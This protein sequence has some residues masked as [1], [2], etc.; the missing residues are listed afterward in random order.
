MHRLASDFRGLENRYTRTQKWGAGTLG[1]ATA[2]CTSWWSLQSPTPQSVYGCGTVITVA[3]VTTTLETLKA[4][5]RK[6]SSLW[7]DTSWSA[8]FENAIRDLKFATDRLE[9]TTSSE[10]QQ[11]KQLTQACESGLAPA[12]LKSGSVW[13]PYPNDPLGVAPKGGPVHVDLL[14]RSTQCKALGSFVEAMT[15]RKTIRNQRRGVVGEFSVPFSK[16]IWLPAL[17]E[18]GTQAKKSANQ[19]YRSYLR[20]EYEW[21]AS[22]CTAR[23]KLWQF[24]NSWDS[25]SKLADSERNGAEDARKAEIACERALLAIPLLPSVSGRSADTGTALPGGW[26][27]RPVM[28][29]FG[30]AEYDTGGE[31]T[32]AKTEQYLRDG[33][34]SLARFYE[35]RP[36]FLNRVNACWEA[37]HGHTK[38]WSSKE[39]EKPRRKCKPLL[40]DTTGAFKTEET[41]INN[42]V[43]FVEKSWS[44]ADTSEKAAEEEEKQRREDRKAEIRFEAHDCQQRCYRPTVKWLC[45]KGRMRGQLFHSA[46]VGVYDI[47][48]GCNCRAEIVA[49]GCDYAEPY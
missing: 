36:A 41:I 37:L 39:W 45:K 10:H 20:K 29:P 21:S 3:A 44:K 43:D 15:T 47:W 7:T 22:L 34:N 4:N 23:S 33:L 31:P 14:H 2:A 12:D 25:L 1:L 17:N 49:E 5:G 42:W 38:G 40:K 24:T 30:F 6:S 28:V 32:A 11:L 35:A 27:P 16:Q 19:Q 8:R 13:K 46:V 18:T 26:A 48:G 9:K